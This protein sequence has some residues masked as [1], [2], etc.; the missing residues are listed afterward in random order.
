MR[1]RVSVR[2]QSE[3][4]D[5]EMPEKSKNPTLRMW[6]KNSSVRLSSSMPDCRAKPRPDTLLITSPHNHGAHVGFLGSKSDRDPK[7]AQEIRCRR[8]PL[9]RLLPRRCATVGWKL[10]VKW[11][12]VERIRC[13]TGM[14]V[15]RPCTG[16]CCPVF[17]DRSCTGL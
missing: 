3:V 14:E 12:R 11:K 13:L 17:P 10:Q 4:S 6:G 5:L 7:A 8:R 15:V 2:S 16:S 1:S 9:L